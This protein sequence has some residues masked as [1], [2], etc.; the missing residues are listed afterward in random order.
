VTFDNTAAEALTRKGGGNI[1]KFPNIGDMVKIKITGLE[2]RQQTDFITGEPITWADGKAKM[3]FVFTGIDQD[4]QEETRIFAKGFM[5]GAIKDALTKAD[6]NLEAGG[7]LAVKYTEDEPPSKVGLN[8]A[9]K[10]VAQYQPPKTASIS[11]DDLM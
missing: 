9:K 8:P 10:Y 1:A 11:A 2:E 4:T 7:V 5:L 6:C 3:Q